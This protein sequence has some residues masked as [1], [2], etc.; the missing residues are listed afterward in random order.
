MEY[1]GNHLAEAGF[2][3]S[4]PRLPGHGTNHQDFLSVSWRDWLRRCID[5]YIELASKYERVS[6]AGLSMGGL[7]TIMLAVEFQVERIALAAPALTTTNP[8]IRLTPLLRC[9]VTSVPNL[10]ESQEEEPDPDARYLQ[11][12]YR[13]RSWIGPIAELRNLQRTALSRLRHLESKTLTIVSKGDR[14]VP[15]TVA[16]LIENRIRS[17]EKKRIVLENSPHV[18]VNGR[19]RERVADEITE[20]FR[21]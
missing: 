14:T 4:I 21:R 20:W 13:H 3:V 5:E 17:A 9:I 7:L 2:S 10:H 11:N 6:V 8:L 19:D 12:E 16:D 1:L 15:I 18:M